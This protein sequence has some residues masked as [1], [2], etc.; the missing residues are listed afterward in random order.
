MTTNALREIVEVRGR[1]HRSVR[2][3]QDWKEG[4]DLSGYLLTPTARGLAKRM[5]LGLGEQGG[6]RA[7]SVTGPYGSG[8]SAFALF[9]TDLLSRHTPYYPE[10]QKLR[11]N[12]GFSAR[13]LL[14]VLVVGQRAPIKPAVLRALAESLEPVD[15]SLAKEVNEAGSKKHISDERVTVLFEQAADSAKREGLGGLFV[16]LDEF[17]KFLEYAALHPE[18]EALFAS[19]AESDEYETSLRYASEPVAHLYAHDTQGR[20]VGDE[21]IY[22]LA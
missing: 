22:F 11:D 21:W 17:G 16:V 8:K 6:S 9:L 13:P 18:T 20:I 14:P 1:F 7:W 10:G 2:L 12:L 3:T 4:R 5:L 15:S 19:F